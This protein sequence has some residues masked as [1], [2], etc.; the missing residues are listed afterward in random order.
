MFLGLCLAMSYDRV[1]ICPLRS[2]HFELDGD[3]VWALSYCP[4]WPE[5]EEDDSED[6]SGLVSSL[7]VVDVEPAKHFVKTGK[8]RS[9]V[10]NLIKCQGGTIAGT[11]A[12]THV[13][14]LLGQSESGRL[15]FEKLVPAVRIFSQHSSLMF[16]KNWII[17]LI[18][19][20]SHLHSLGIIHRDL[21][22]ANLIFSEDK[23]RLVICDLESRWGQ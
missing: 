17:Q 9:E 11:A 22:T 23:N 8:Y 10:F 16:Y 6:V 5:I 1:K 15:V 20:L 14:Q 3:E 2:D 21:R 12:S 19:G 4:E 7:L 13:V 18:D